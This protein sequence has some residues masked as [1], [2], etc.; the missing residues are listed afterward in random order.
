MV[1]VLIFT[2][3]NVFDALMLVMLVMVVMMMV[4]LVMVVMIM[5]KTK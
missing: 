5:V 3:A 2:K 1:A 4:M